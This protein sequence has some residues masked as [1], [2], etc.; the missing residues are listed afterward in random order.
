MEERQLLDPIRNVADT[1]V[2][3][4]N[5]NVHELRAHI[6]PAS[7]TATSQASTGSCLSFGFKNGVPLDADMVFDVSFFP[8]PTLCRSSAKDG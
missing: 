8:I 4:S 2:D 7:V 6:Q 5:F 3:T 1:L